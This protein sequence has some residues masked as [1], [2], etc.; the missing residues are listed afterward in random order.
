MFSQGKIIYR[1]FISI[2]LLFEISVQK[3]KCTYLQREEPK[4]SRASML[5]TGHCEIRFFLK[6]HFIHWPIWL[7]PCHKQFSQEQCFFIQMKEC[8]YYHRDDPGVIIILIGH[9]KC[10]KNIAMYVLSFGQ[11]QTLHTHTHTHTQDSKCNPSSLGYKV[12]ESLQNFPF[13]FSWK[14]IRA[15]L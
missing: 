14:Q 12:K 15:P 2:F 11:S 4:D 1:C 8:W 7:I 9:I 6:S 3:T 13:S 5:Y 10:H